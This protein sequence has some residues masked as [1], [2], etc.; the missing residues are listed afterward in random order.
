MRRIELS[1]INENRGRPI[2]KYQ[3]YHGGG[4]AGGAKGSVY[5]RQTD[6]SPPV[7]LGDGIAWTLSAD[8]KWVTGFSSTDIAKRNYMLTPTGAGEEVEIPVPQLPDK[9]A[10]LMGW[11]PGERN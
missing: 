5:L 8:A 11:L 2:E 3:G 10:L 9:F 4:E 7:R 6:G 1:A